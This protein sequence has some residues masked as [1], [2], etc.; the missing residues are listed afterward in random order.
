MALNQLAPD[1]MEVRN[2][3]TNQ[4]AKYGLHTQSYIKIFKTLGNLFIPGS[5]LMSPNAED[6]SWPLVVD[7]LSRPGSVRDNVE[8]LL[9]E[10]HIL[11]LELFD[12]PELLA[13]VDDTFSGREDHSV[14]ISQLLTIEHGLLKMI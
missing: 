13:I 1:L 2:S 12:R 6:R 8:H 3:N 7:S 11:D 4:K 10:G 5:F 9:L 14:V